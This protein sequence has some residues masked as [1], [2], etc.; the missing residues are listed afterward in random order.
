MIVKMKKNKNILSALLFGILT[1]WLALPS[2]AI[3]EQENLN[4]SDIH[5]LEKTLIETTTVT[6][7]NNPIKVSVY[8]DH[9]VKVTALSGDFDHSLN[10]D[11][12]LNTS[13]HSN[14]QSEGPDG[15]YEGWQPA[16]YY[17][18]VDRTSNEDGLLASAVNI[19]AY[20]GILDF[21]TEVTDGWNSGSWS[22][23]NDTF[24]KMVLSQNYK[25]TGIGITISW[26]PSFI[27]EKDSA[28]W[29]SSDYYD[30]YLF[31]EREPCST[32]A[33]LAGTVITIEDGADFYT[34]TD[35]V[36]KARTTIEKSW[37]NIYYNT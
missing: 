5:S 23:D 13:N 34:T 12:L 18:E 9:G 24:L 10:P 36:Y 30:T 3:G 19:R 4:N 31:A 8:D 1:L 37:H 35:K 29:T 6:L 28:S 16:R 14:I 25:I 32:S 21:R 7:N 15:P 11:E 33:R 22:G 20:G 27:V 26:P 2:C 17:V